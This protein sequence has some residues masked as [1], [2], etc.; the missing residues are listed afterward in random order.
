MT[1]AGQIAIT[2]PDGAKLSMEMGSTVADV[3]A[4]ISR[5]LAKKTIAG[6]VDDQPVDLSAALDSDVSLQLVTLDSPEGLS[7]IRHSAAHVMAGAVQDLYPEAKV[8]IGPAVDDGV[9]GF[10]YDFDFDRGFTE[11]DL[12]RITKRMNE[13]VSQDLVFER[14]LVSRD[15]ARKL[16]Q[17]MGEEY[18]LELLD[19]IEEGETVSLYRH[20]EFVDLCRGPH[21][22]STK[23]LK[24]FKLMSVAGA[25]WRGDSSNKMLARIYGNAFAA[26]KQ[27]DEHLQRLE[28]AKKRDHRLLGRELDLFSFSQD[29]GGGLVLWHPKGARVRSIIEEFWRRSHYDYGYELVYSPHVGRADLWQTSGHLEFY[30]ENM[31]A[32]MEIEGNPFYVK[33]MNC[34]FHIEI[35]RS[36]MRSYR[37]M[38]VRYAELGTVYRYEASGVLHG[39]MRVRG[40]TQDDAHIFCRADQLDAEIRRCLQHTFY[41]LRSFGF[42]DFEVYLSTRPEKYVGEEAE[43]DKATSAL[44]SALEA[45]GIEFQIDPGE[46]VFYGPKIDIKIRDSLNRVWQCTTVQVDFNLPQRFKV[47]YVD[48][49]NQRVQP[50]M[51]HR[52]L[53]GSIERFFGVLLEHHAGRF[54]MWLAPTQAVVLPVTN[55]QDEFARKVGDELKAKGLRVQ[56]DDRNEKLGFRIREARLA[57]VPYLLVVG[58]REVEKNGV[59]AKVGKGEDLGFLPLNEAMERMVR[60]AEWPAPPTV[61]DDG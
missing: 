41:L 57:R 20:G 18:K 32:P 55:K 50:F 11:E 49:D 23:R 2:L 25:Y 30:S 51:V 38:P 56:V 9:N 27:L 35:Y 46:G 16:F 26:K 19:A 31:Y 39:L 59:S 10:Y 37:E 54:P 47:E 43:W 29:V 24:A 8:T 17:E 48:K 61:K 52:A 28:E 36:N 22:P 7:I 6:V 60:D 21:L 34:P 13:V 44:K 3:A 53:L 15:E 42:E 40:F 4:R 12:E 1:A 14:Q 45:E 33:P 5:S 58:D